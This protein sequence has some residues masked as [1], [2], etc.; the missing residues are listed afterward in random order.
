M[1]ALSF[2][3][4]LWDKMDRDYHIGGAPFNFAAHL[5]LC[6]AQSFFLSALGMDDLGEK[7]LKEVQKRGL[8]T[9]YLCRNSLP[10]GVVEVHLEKGI[11]Q[12]DI[13][14]DRAWDQISP[15]TAVTESILRR[16]WDLFY[17]GTL[18]QR[19]KSNRNWLHQVLLPKISTDNVFFDVNLRQHYYDRE[20]LA[21]TMQYTNI[22]KLNDE[23]APLISQLILEK[24][25]DEKTYFDGMKKRFPLI[26]MIIL[27]RGKDGASIFTAEGEQHFKPHGHVKVA[28]TVGAGDSFSA[29]F[30]YAWHQTSDLQRSAEFALTVADWVVSCHGALPPYNEEIKRELT[31]FQ[32]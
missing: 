12:Y 8:S 7:A 25:F 18:A 27:T 4:I 22:L 29:S 16:K 26:R 20:I 11:P 28:D 23:E 1:K 15:D 3:E 19:S 9:E 13:L 2:G 31:G 6:G 5:A 30:S 10:T 21:K 14:K 32:N 24:D 17:L